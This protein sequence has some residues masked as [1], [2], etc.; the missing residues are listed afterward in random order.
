MLKMFKDP[1][2]KIKTFAVIIFWVGVVISVISTMVMFANAGDL[3]VGE[4]FVFFGFVNLVLGPIASY[5]IG[6]LI[7]GF[8]ECVDKASSIERKVTERKQGTDL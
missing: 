8:G 3:Y 1:G 6:L 4:M 2:S 5:I 7:Y